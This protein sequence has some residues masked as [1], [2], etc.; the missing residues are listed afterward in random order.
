MSPPLGRR[1]RFDKLWFWLH[2]PVKS[3]C[4]LFLQQRTKLLTR[5]KH[6]GL[7][8]PWSTSWVLQFVQNIGEDFRGSC[9]LCRS[10]SVWVEMGGAVNYKKINKEELSLPG[11]CIDV[12]SAFRM[13]APLVRLRAATAPWTSEDSDTDLWQTHSRSLSAS[14]AS[15]MVRGTSNSSAGVRVCMSATPDIGSSDVVTSL[16]RR[17]DTFP[18]PIEPKMKR[19]RAASHAMPSGMRFESGMAMKSGKAGVVGW[20]M[21]RRRRGTSA[22]EY[23]GFIPQAERKQLNL[24]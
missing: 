3:W 16:S 18:C 17:K 20:T 23:V 1:Q 13:T 11:I 12:T 9:R 14:T 6:N 10:G 5:D 7:I 4:G 19:D 15:P 2:L 24:I 21:N 22:W 8:S